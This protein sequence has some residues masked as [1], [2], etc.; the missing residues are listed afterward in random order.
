MDISYMICA[1]L[2]TWVSIIT[3][4]YNQSS[5][6][7]QTI[8]SVLEQNYRD[9]EYIVVDGGSTDGKVDIINKYVTRLTW[10][11]SRN[12]SGQGRSY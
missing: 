3:P 10:W 6:L 12:D 4:S 5:F 11:V 8:R 9:I 7:A 2:M 1:V